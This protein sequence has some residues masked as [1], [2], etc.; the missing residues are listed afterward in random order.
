M[1][2]IAAFVF[3]AALFLSSLMNITAQ[4]VGGILRGT[5][6]DESNAVIG[7][8]KLVLRDEKGF[9]RRTVSDA[10]GNFSF[11][12]LPFG[13]YRL[14]VEKEGFSETEREINI[15]SVE[16]NANA[17]LSASAITE[18]VT[19][20]MDSAEAAVSETLKLGET[21]H[22]TPRTLTVLNE[23]RIREQNF[24]QVSDLLNYVQ[25]ASPN[26]YR[27]GGYHFYTRG[28]RMTPEDTRLDGFAGAVVGGGFGASMFGVEEV[29]LLKG[30]AGLIYGSGGGA[31]A[32]INLVSKKPQEKY[33]TRLDLQTRGFQGRGVSL[34]E[35]PSFSADIDS[36]GAILKNNRILY[37]ALAR[38]ENGNYFTVDTADRDRYLQGALTFK[39]DNEG[40]YTLTPSAQ[41]VRQ[42]RAFGGGIIISPSTSLDASKPNSQR[43]NQSDLSPFDVNLYDGRRVDETMWGA[44]D[45]RGIV[46]DKLRVNSTY[47][48][49]SFD[50][51]INSFTPQVTNDAQRNLLRT[52]N[53]VSRVQSKSSINRNYQ[54]FN[55][56]AVYDW[57]QNGWW[58]NSTQ[59]GFYQRIVDS[60]SSSLQGSLQ[61][62][63]NIYTGQTTSPLADT[64]LF[65][66]SA[67]WTRDRTWNAF[68]QNRTSLADGRF[69][70]TLGLNYGQNKPTETS[71]TR[72]SGLIPNFS[73]VY[74]ATDELAFY[75]SYST[76]FNPS[77]PTLEDAQG[78]RGRF[79]PTL[80]KN[81]EIGVKYDLLNR[82]LNLNAAVFQNQLENALVQSDVGVLNTLGNRFYIASGT[83]RS[84]G[85]EISGAFQL[86]ND[87]SVTGGVTYTDAIYKGFP[88]SAG[89]AAS[90][91]IPN[92]R[93]EKTPRWSSNIYTRYERSEGYLKGFG[94][95]L[96]L[97]WQGSRIGSNGAQTFASPYPLILPSFTKTDA[98]ASYR[99][100]KFAE[101]AV[102]VDNAFNKLIFVNATVGSNIEV[103]APRT[104]SLRTTFNF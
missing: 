92:S 18:T 63:I 45:F 2:K 11:G 59:I 90:A 33:F 86:R 95:G 91:P 89:K 58:R 96:G 55:A 36:T 75:G 82:R 93:A 68:L 1:K 101:V 51:F 37:R 103:A 78:N 98:Y 53:L 64:I 41:F 17:T 27:S 8:A 83:R 42:N 23:K 19:I 16:Q 87:L 38:I 26:S 9:S 6:T 60:R 88:A 30:P 29:V 100:N 65:L 13:K 54:N 69:V 102:N 31:G 44:L 10:E 5:I 62:P 66:P 94:A 14:T 15:A 72:K 74:N 76:S 77:D 39:L 70:F 25:G 80:G 67:Q 81:Y 50:S 61:S 97:S 40:R 57:K 49:I 3:G 22:N 48:Y 7:E 21:I 104:V 46:T 34:F 47:R 85:A 99:F 52:R 24:R 71:A 84:R 43:I 73:A 35:R 28:Y 4:T 56:D 20:I 32:L 79:A 12:E